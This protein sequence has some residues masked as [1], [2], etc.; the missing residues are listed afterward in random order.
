MKPDLQ[1][2]VDGMSSRMQ[3]ERAESQMTLGELID[4]LGQLPGDTEI[5]NLT[6]PHSYRGYYSD[7]AFE[8]GP[9]TRTAADLLVECRSAMGK[10]FIG[11][12]GGDFV[13]GELTPVWVAEYGSCGDRLMNID[14][15]GLGTS[16]DEY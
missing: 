11:Y 7:L 14:A 4:V 3:R 13:M 10:V 2:L 8:L 16:L 12:K 15:D 5:P 6:E 9:E 1:D